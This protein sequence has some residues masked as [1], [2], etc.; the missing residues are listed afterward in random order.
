MRDIANSLPGPS[1]IA[2]RETLVGQPA[3]EFQ[4]QDESG[5]NVTL[6]RLLRGGPLILHFYRGHW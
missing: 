1:E 4:L 5:A 3:P 2:D 6:R